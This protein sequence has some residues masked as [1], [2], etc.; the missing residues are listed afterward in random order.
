[1]NQSLARLNQLPRDISEAEFLECCGSSR[2]AAAMT[3]A[4][5]FA[6]T[7]EVAAKADE[8][9]WSL[10]KEDWLEAFRSHP[11]IGERKAAT[12][13]TEQAQNWSAQEQ[14]GMATAST[15]TMTEL[16]DC[17]REYE[18]RFGFIF[19]VCASGKSSSDMLALVRQRLTN[20][21]AAELGIA[22]EEQRRITR[23]RLRKLLQ[24]EK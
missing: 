8:I 17:N 1:M 16:A 2:W 24:T 3:N 7:D 22:A 9:W 13:Q 20:D 4:R 12:T 10:S 19:I 23:L 18:R 15:E 5:P 21:P 6:N 11:K 14:S